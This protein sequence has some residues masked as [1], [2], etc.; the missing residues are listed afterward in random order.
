MSTSCS[1]G[2]III[3]HQCHRPVKCLVER[4]GDQSACR[5]NCGIRLESSSEVGQW[6]CV[7]G[8]A[9]YRQTASDDHY[10]QGSRVKSILH[11]NSCVPSTRGWVNFLIQHKNIWNNHGN[12]NQYMIK[13]PISHCP[14]PGSVF[15]KGQNDKMNVMWWESPGFLNTIALTHHQSRNQC[16]NFVHFW[17]YLFKLC[18]LESGK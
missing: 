6:M 11:I 13:I 9:S 14:S 3:S 2:P 17:E 8:L 7:T 18:I 5:L 16:K 4:E 10:Q 12:W 1:P 15:C